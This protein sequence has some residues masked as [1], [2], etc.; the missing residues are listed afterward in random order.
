MATTPVTRVTDLTRRFRLDVDTATYPSVQYDEVVGRAA[1]RL[2]E[3]IRTVDDEVEEDEG[4]MREAVTGYSWRI[5]LQLRNS[6]NLAGTSRNTVHTFLRNKFLALRTGTAAANEFGIRFY[7]RN[8]ISGEAHEG[9]VYVK[10]WQA[11]DDKASSDL[12]T[13]V[14]QG[15]G[16]LSDITNPASSQV[17]AVTSVSP[18][19]GSTSGGELVMI[20]GDHFTDATDVD[21]GATECTDFTIVS[22]SL[23][24]AVAPAQSAA[25]VQVKVTNAAGASSD[26]DADNYT[27]A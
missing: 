10:S 4:A 9:R 24:A 12:V 19:S 16:A 26:T 5:E 8:G 13:I 7:D 18:T 20:S 1:L 21:F 23:I 27:Y 25:T 17:P 14:L 2:V 11:S 22:D 15:Q 3:E 6:L